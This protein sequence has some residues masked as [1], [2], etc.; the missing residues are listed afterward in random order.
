MGINLRY[1]IDNLA[2]LEPRSVCAS[3]QGH[4]TKPVERFD[5]AKTDLGSSDCGT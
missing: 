3:I 2:K 1:T 4:S 5:L